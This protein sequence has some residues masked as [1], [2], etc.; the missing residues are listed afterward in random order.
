MKE[1]QLL[2]NGFELP[3]G[4]M[5]EYSGE[6]REYKVLTLWQPWAT[7]LVYGIKKIETRPKPTSWTAEKGTYLIHAAQKWTKEQEDI[8]LTE[9]FK[10]ELDKLGYAPLYNRLPLGCIIGAVNVLGCHKIT[11]CNSDD[12]VNEYAKIETGKII[13]EPELSFGDYRAG[14][15]AWLCEN[16]RVLKTPIPYKG[17]QG[18]YQ[19]FNGDDSLIEYL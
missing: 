14:R 2:I 8:C 7:L 5:R 4:Q 13:N 11:Y 9:P 3:A 19:K 17:G 15:Y 6:M 10:S 16:H 18:Y 1:Q 12:F